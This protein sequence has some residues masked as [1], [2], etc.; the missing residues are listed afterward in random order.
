MPTSQGKL[1][2]LK[3]TLQLMNREELVT[4]IPLD[5]LKHDD[6]VE[7]IK[8]IFG[9]SFNPKFTER[10]H[11]EAEG[12]PFFTEELLK[13][14]VL[15]GI[16]YRH[17]AVWE[18]KDISKIVIPGS[19]KDT[20]MR[21][22]NAL[23]KDCQEVL[24]YASVIGQIFQ[25]QTL[26]KT[27]GKDRK[28]L[29]DLL[30]EI[31][32]RGI[33]HSERNIIKFDHAKLQEV[34]YADI[35]GYKKTI[36]HEETA[37]AIEELNREKLNI[38][39]T[40]LAYHYQQAGIS[41]KIAEYALLA[42]ETAEKKFTPAEAAQHYM[43]ALQALEKMKPTLENKEKMMR[44]ADKIAYMYYITGDWDMSMNYSSL[45]RKLARETKNQAM[46]A[47]SYRNMGMIQ[48]DK[49]EY[50]K[51]LE[52]LQNALK[53][54]EEINDAHGMSEA[55][56]WMGKICWRTGKLDTA[57]KF[58]ETC[59]NIAVETGDTPMMAKA[60]MDIGNVHYMKGEYKECLEH[61]GRSLSIFEKIDDKNEI[62][63]AYNNIGSAYLEMSDWE[64]AIE[65]FEKCID[66][67]RKIGYLRIIGYGL[68]NA[69]GCYAQLNQLDKAKEYTD[70]ALNIFTK[71]GEKRMISPC[72]RNYGIIYHK[73]NEWDKSVECFEKAI[74]VNIGNLEGL[75]Q[76]YF[77]YG[78]MFA[79]KGDKEKARERFEK[80]IEVYERLGNK[81]KVEEVKKEMGDAE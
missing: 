66:I 7:I 64:R 10:L 36:M 13:A 17:N 61:Y 65:W 24:K 38:V 8:S 78:K 48:I 22:V 60:T 69:A 44:T 70:D 32:K 55:Q 25:F 29:A 28:D 26:A 76:T 74:N 18:A 56:Y 71:L 12:N 23:D 34:I 33:L 80:S 45:V 50:D 81:K 63:R 4:E 15:D 52:N 40:E 9:H 42:A 47:E 73:K 62:A 16:I 77:H 20:V 54:S 39:A 43:T 58:L 57:M 27:T 5:R 67:S 53:M 41:E 2:P 19:V 51:A 79:D 68:C 49:A 6:A 14:L 37:K 1:H 21:L 3:E 11:K 30:E 31:E 72:H 59:Y 75:S 35:P 46:V